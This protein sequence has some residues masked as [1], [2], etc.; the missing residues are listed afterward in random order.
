MKEY[1]T[2]IVKGNGYSGIDSFMKLY[3]KAKANYG[4]YTK[5]LKAWRDKYGMKYVEQQSAEDKKALV[6]VLSFIKP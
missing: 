6:I 4:D 3:R 1:L 5:R 2:H